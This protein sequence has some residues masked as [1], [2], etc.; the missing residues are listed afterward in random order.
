MPRTRAEILP[1]LTAAQADLDAAQA[2][3][4]AADETQATWLSIFADAD[5]AKQNAT[6]AGASGTLITLLSQARAEAEAELTTA[7]TA[8]DAA[9]ATLGAKRETVDILTAELAAA[10][11]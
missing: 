6:R 4:V 10:T 11:E 9:R 1:D 5:T 7:R 8:A 2:A 3:S